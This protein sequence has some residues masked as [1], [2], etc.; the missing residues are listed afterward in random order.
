M[1]VYTNL[2]G[3]IQGILNIYAYSLLEI[4]WWYVNKHVQQVSFSVDLKYTNS[5]IVLHLVLTG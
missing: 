5:I 2:F 4:N 3:C 1:G